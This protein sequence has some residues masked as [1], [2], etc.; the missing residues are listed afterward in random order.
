MTEKEYEKTLEELH[1]LLECAKQS[2]DQAAIGYASL[3]NID[4]DLPTS[5]KL[6][7][8]LSLDD[9]QKELQYSLQSAAN[10]YHQI[11]AHIEELMKL[12]ET[13]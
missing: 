11:E 13:L 7:L 12:K 3:L 4:I 10:A 6:K 2:R 1:K 5:W 9:A 8:G